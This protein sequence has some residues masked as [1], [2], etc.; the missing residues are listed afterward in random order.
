VDFAEPWFEDNNKI[1]SLFSE[2]KTTT[3]CKIHIKSSKVRIRQN[4]MVMNIK[5]FTAV[6]KACN[7]GRR[8]CRGGACSLTVDDTA[9]SS[10]GTQW[11]QP[12][13]WTPNIHMAHNLIDMWLIY[14]YTHGSYTRI[15]MAHTHIYTWLIYT[16][17][18][19]TWLIYMYTHG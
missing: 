6:L 11:W 13:Y 18:I 5:A 10:A 12:S 8:V 9:R 14:T 16:W 2:T 17:F 7:I 15:H 4:V 3:D 1:N 19:Y